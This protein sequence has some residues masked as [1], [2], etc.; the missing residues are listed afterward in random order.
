MP[1]WLAPFS[2]AEQ[3]ITASA[4]QGTST[5]TALARPDDIA[6]HYQEIMANAGVVFKTQSDGI[7]MS[8]IASSDTISAVVR[9]R[10]GEEVCTVKVSYAVKQNDPRSVGAVTRE[11]AMFAPAS[12]GPKREPLSPYARAPY[13]WIIQSVIVPASNPR[14]YNLMYYEAPTDRSVVAPLPLTASATVVD[15][16]PTDCAFMMQDSSGHVATYQKGEEL[17]GKPLA[18]G[19][20]AAYPMKCSGIDIFLH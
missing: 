8:I 1:E 7:G 5:Y 10:E 11:R 17:R 13:T 2:H 3:S 15:V 4:T 12:S 6:A 18:P 19:T 14:K 20:W 9:I 16:F